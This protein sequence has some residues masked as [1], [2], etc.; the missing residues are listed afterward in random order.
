LDRRDVRTLRGR[1]ASCPR[2]PRDPCPCATWRKPSHSAWQVLVGSVA[3]NVRSA[4]PPQEGCAAHAP[5]SI[6]SDLGIPRAARRASARRTRKT[7]I[8]LLIDPGRRR[9]CVGKSGDSGGA[10]KAV[11]DGHRAAWSASKRSRQRCRTLHDGLAENG[12]RPQD[13]DIPR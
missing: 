11:L 6:G 12:A 7:G 8:R 13:G 1:L 9:R 2:I 5:T 4:L 3:S 10:Q